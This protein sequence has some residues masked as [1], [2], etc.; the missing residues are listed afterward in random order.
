[1]KK[2]V[3]FEIH[4]GGRVVVKPKGFSGPAC[5]AA[6]KDIERELGTVVEQ[7]KTPEFFAR[8]ETTQ[9]AQQGA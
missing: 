3:E 4:K 1:M 6:T 2:T 5:Q 7:E 9:S 8:S